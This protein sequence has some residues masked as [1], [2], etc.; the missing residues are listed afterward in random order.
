MSQIEEINDVPSLASKAMAIALLVVVFAGFIF[1]G[2]LSY[3]EETEKKRKEANLAAFNKSGE[4]ALDLI[5]LTSAPELASDQATYYEGFYSICVL[6]RKLR[7]SLAKDADAEAMAPLNIMHEGCKEL[8]KLALTER[9]RRA[10]IASLAGRVLKARA[11]T[12][13]AI[14][15]F[16]EE[17]KPEVTPDSQV[18]SMAEWDK[19]DFS[20]KP[21]KN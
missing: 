21:V 20:S 5:K 7:S 10:Y 8:G 12:E 3:K 9:V 14:D 6:N 17:A 1:G 19:T 2:H 18:K 15:L 11:L 16:S 4:M 13:G